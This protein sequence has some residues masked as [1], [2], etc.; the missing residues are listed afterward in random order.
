[1]GMKQLLLECAYRQWRGQVTLTFSFLCRQTR[2]ASCSL[3][4]QSGTLKAL[5]LNLHP[6]AQ[7]H[8]FVLAHLRPRRQQTFSLEAE[9]QRGTEIYSASQV[10]LLGE[11]RCSE[12]FV[13][14]LCM[15]V[16]GYFNTTP[17]QLSPVSVCVCVCLWVRLRMCFSPTTCQLCALVCVF[18]PQR[19]VCVCV[20]KSVCV[21]IFLPDS[22]PECVWWVNRCVS[23]GHWQ[24]AVCWVD[25]L[26]LRG[27]GSI[28]NTENV[29]QNLHFSSTF[30]LFVHRVTCSNSS[31]LKPFCSYVYYRL[32]V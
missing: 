10:R 31:Q 30:S 5:R 26:I 22:L 14:H 17:C 15:C 32:S 16:C 1:M 20:C 23:P 28:K 9:R 25:A 19:Y 3:F 6:A 11:H 12:G 24:H 29:L 13:L 8:S 27:G 4:T 21:S 7:H 18:L 2:A